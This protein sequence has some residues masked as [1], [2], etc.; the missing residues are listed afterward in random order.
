VRRPRSRPTRRQLLQGG[1]ALTGLGLLA[2][3]GLAP[4]PG[5]WGHGPRRIGYLATGTLQTSPE[6]WDSCSI[7]L[8][9]EKASAGCPT[10]K[11]KQY[12]IR[13]IGV[14]VAGGR[15]GHPTRG[16]GHDGAP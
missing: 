11:R 1:L 6:L 9:G 12:P 7:S 14:A 3:C 13:S 10:R 4:L 2:G 8:T 15:A 5:L 16:S